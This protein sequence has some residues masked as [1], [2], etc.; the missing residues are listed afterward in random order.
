[1]A[2][3][4]RI[5]RVPSVGVEY[6]DF[7]YATIGG[8]ANGTSVLS[9]MARM[10]LDPWQEAVKL[11][12]LPSK[13]ATSRLTALIAAVPGIPPP[14]EPGLIAARLIKLL[15]QRGHLGVVQGS[16]LRL[17]LDRLKVLAPSRAVLPANGATRP[18]LALPVVILLIAL[19]LT[20]QWYVARS[21]VSKPSAPA[22][23]SAQ[24][25]STR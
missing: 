7:L 13:A 6:G 10:K 16:R 9:A 12:E 24:S 19:V 25:S 18:R 23:S 15:P 5:S 4:S 21:H 17:M 3:T 14:D 8:D 11:A 22:S 2:E 20:V 1:M